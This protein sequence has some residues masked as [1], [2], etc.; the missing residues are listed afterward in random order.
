M[1]RM[2]R[3]VAR[4]A[5][6]LFVAGFGSS[7]QQPEPCLAPNTLLEPWY[8]ANDVLTSMTVSRTGTDHVTLALRYAQ[9]LAQYNLTHD[10]TFWGLEF[11][12]ANVPCGGL[13][14]QA[15]P[16]QFDLAS[17][18]DL[19][20]GTSVSERYA[21][22]VALPAS[23]IAQWIS[24]HCGLD[25]W[26]NQVLYFVFVDRWNNG[27]TSNDGD[28]VPGVQA[29]ANYQGGD[30]AGVTAKIQDGY[31]NDLGVTALWLTV[32]MDNPDV[33]GAGS[34][35]YMYSAYH[36]YWPQNL[37]QAEQ[38]F[39]TLAELQ[40]L[41]AAAHARHLRVV[42]DYVM[43]DVHISS[44]VYVQHPEWF[45]PSTLDGQSC[46][47]GSS[48]CGWDSPH[49]TRCWLTPYLADFNFTNP[50]ARA[51]S[52]SNA[53]W[54][55]QQTGADGL[56]LD[57]PRLVETSWISD[58]RSRVKTQ[59]EPLRA[60][61]VFVVGDT[62]TG[63]PAVMNSLVNPDTLLD[64]Q[65]EYP[66]RAQ[67]VTNVLL[68]QG[69]MSDLEARMTADE[70]TFSGGLMSTFVGN[71]VVPRS[72]HFAEDVPLW[73]SA[74]ADGKDRSW[75]D[76]PAAP[77]TTSAYERLAVAFAV[78][79]TN[80]GIPLIYY[81][82]EVGMPGAGDP[83]NRRFMQWSGYSAAQSLLLTRVKK[84]TA[85]RAAHEALW[86]GARTTLSITTDTW[87]YRMTSGADTVYVA[88]NRGDAT[89]NVSG[90]PSASLT[91][92]VSGSTVSGPTISVAPRTA[93][94]LVP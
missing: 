45:W 10:T 53:I 80:R 31:F 87:G 28:A 43:N 21:M 35:G 59:I 55:M 24:D 26:R 38:R 56:R 76:Q 89:Q 94:V 30:W 65:F 29:P 18:L 22:Y 54:W 74:W 58:L 49:L 7:A 15:V 92:F 73:T 84:L 57:S 51:F 75:T 62:F 33:S 88:V 66:L 71:H 2:H 79:M 60:R 13:A 32:P 37:S 85:A 36:G 91:D 69:S 6:L 72:I 82:D 14:S 46:I 78:V 19:V 12:P 34:D 50:Q 61:H 42:L 48:A 9:L 17:D 40:E 25:E 64:G 77:D 5:L 11:D 44:P 90:F 70:S 41:V 1:T 8:S 81:G 52:V 93:M 63:D 4:L 20:L 67:L 68:R 47:C 86:K 23:V 83:D 39:G 27:T 3:V 16:G